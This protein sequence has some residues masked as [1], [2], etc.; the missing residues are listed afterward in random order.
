MHPTDFVRNRIQE[1]KINE[2]IELIRQCQAKLD[3]VKPDGYSKI[4]N[5][6]NLFLISVI[7]QLR[8]LGPDQALHDDNLLAVWA[9][10]GYFGIERDCLPDDTEE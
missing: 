5:F 4:C 6:A 3:T 8:Q 9:E 10:L 1:R 2:I 7:G